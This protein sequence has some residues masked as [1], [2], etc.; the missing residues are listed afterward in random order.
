MSRSMDWRLLRKEINSEAFTS[1]LEAAVQYTGQTGNECGFEVK[2]LP[3][4]RIFYYPCH[5]F[6]GD[7]KSVDLLE[8]MNMGYAL[9]LFEEETG[10]A[11]P[12][13][14]SR[15]ESGWDAYLKFIMWL[16]RH[17]RQ[18]P[19]AATWIDY[20][21][22]EDRKEKERKSDEIFYDNSQDIVCSTGL[23]FHTHPGRAT[24][25][26]TPDLESVNRLRRFNEGVNPI[27]VIV[28]AENV[29]VFWKGRKEYHITILQ[30]KSDSG[31]DKNSDYETLSRAVR[32]NINETLR[33]QIF[34]KRLVE[35]VPYNIVGGI[36]VPNYKK[37]KIK[38][39]FGSWEDFSQ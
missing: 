22:T 20:P 21:E 2:Y 34:K 27:E 24:Y 13:Y 7:K 31:L 28:G 37:S 17:N 1:G 3:E 35:S 38:K 12:R 16:D 6:V 32:S 19:H 29:S 23:T 18:N 11:V 39:L 8:S 10:L 26:S 5:I 4:H 33:A 15:S 36:F 14:W 9:K 30:E 25:P